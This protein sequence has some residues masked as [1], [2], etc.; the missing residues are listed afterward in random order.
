MVSTRDGLETPMLKTSYLPNRPAAW[1]QVWALPLVTVGAAWIA[2]YGLQTVL[3]AAAPY[4]FFVG[5]VLAATW[6]GG[7]LS[8][9]LATLAGGLLANLSFVGLPNR[10]EVTGTELWDLVVFLGFCTVLVLAQEAMISGI[11]R[12]VML[13]EELALVGR[14]LQHR[15]RNVLTVAEALSQQTGRSASTVEEFNRKLVERLRALGAAQDLLAGESV[16]RVPLSVILSAAAAPF[17]A[18]NRFAGPMTGPEVQVDRKLV[19]PLALIL[20]E[21][22]TNSVKYGAL[23]VPSGSVALNWSR[24]GACAEIHWVERGGPPVTPPAREGFGS[25]LLRTALPT[26][27]G[28]VHLHFDPSGLRCEISVGVAEPSEAAP[29]LSQEKTARVAV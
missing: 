8:G 16:E 4:L 20:N 14:E 22:A 2:R 26:S 5:A 18:E 7:R 15:I 25:R 23:S 24:N 11:R 19:V 17:L 13:N 3:G 6:W 28:A 1:W 21:L 10:L 29:K 12:E 27:S 9:L